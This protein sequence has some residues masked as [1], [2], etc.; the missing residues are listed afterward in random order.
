MTD[1]MVSVRYMVND[2]DTAVE[3]YTRHF[4][5]EPGYVASPAFAE[6]IKGNLRLL[7]AG[8]EDGRA[9]NA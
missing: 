3:F 8:T 6:V 7:L 5:F 1:G 9:A 4:N 2:V